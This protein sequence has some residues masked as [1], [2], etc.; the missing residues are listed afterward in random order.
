MNTNKAIRAINKETKDKLAELKLKYF[1]E[2]CQILEEQ[3]EKINALFD[4]EPVVEVFEEVVAEEIKELVSLE[5]LG[6]FIPTP[7][8]PLLASIATPEPV[9]EEPVK[10]AKVRGKRKYSGGVD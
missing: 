6:E 8:E 10:K 5:S 7:E 2:R 9:T 1:Q 3:V 4:D